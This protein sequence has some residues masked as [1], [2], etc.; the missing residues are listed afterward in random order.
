MSFENLTICQAYKCTQRIY[1]ST[2]IRIIGIKI[3]EEM[4]VFW[5]VDR[6]FFFKDNLMK[7]CNLQMHLLL[8]STF[9][10]IKWL[11]LSSEKMCSRLPSTSDVKWFSWQNM[12]FKYKKWKNC[13]IFLGK[14]NMGRMWFLFESRK[15]RYFSIKLLWEGPSNG[16]QFH[17]DQGSGWFKVFCHQ[18]KDS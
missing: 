2:L 3:E 11:Q 1:W 8:P 18:L 15:E 9:Q 12:K 10:I 14:T 16:Y 4:D 13:I 6:Q 7:W 5:L 17:H